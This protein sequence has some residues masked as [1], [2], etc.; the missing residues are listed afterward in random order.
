MPINNEANRLG[1]ERRAKA[2]QDAQATKPP[3]VHSAQ[4]SRL[5]KK[6][7]HD[8][9]QSNDFTKVPPPAPVD[10]PRQCSSTDIL[11]IIKRAI[12]DVASWLA[13][14][15]SLRTLKRVDSNSDL[16][17]ELKEASMLH[18][19]MLLDD[20]GESVDEDPP[21]PYHESTTE[22]HGYS[23]TKI[24][25]EEM[26]RLDSDNTISIIPTVSR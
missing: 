11:A 24:I 4:K 19:E 23:P 7:M 18:S 25:F 14:I 21:P 26:I 1:L 20:S 17:I 2:L 12:H 9:L 5:Y 3:A 13:R 15:E 8:V 22:A 16:H 10:V 6:L